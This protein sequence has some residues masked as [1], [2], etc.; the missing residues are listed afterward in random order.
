MKI[1]IYY[2][3][4]VAGLFFSLYGCEFS[5]SDIPLTEIEKPSE[6]LPAIRIELKP[7]MDILRIS[8]PTWVTYSVET[9]SHE[10][11]QI[12]LKFDETDLV[13]IN[14]ESPQKLNAYIPADQIEDGMHQLKITTYIATNSGSIAD[15][16]GYEHY[17]YTITWPVYINKH[18]KENLKFTDI[19]LV[20]EGVRLRWPEYSYA[21][22]LRY[23]LSWSWCNNQS[24][25]INITDPSQNSY[26]DDNYVEGIYCS[27]FLMIDFKGGDFCFDQKDFF[28]NIK[29]PVVMVNGDRSVDIKWSHSQNEKNVSLYCIK[30]SAPVYGL[31]EEHDITDLNE[32]TLRL[33]RSIGFGGNYNVQ[34]RYIPKGYDGY[35]S[36]YE[37][38][39]GL[40]IFAL[41]DSIPVF[42][43]AFLIVEENS[44]LI[45]NNGS[46]TK[47]DFVTG[48][49]SSA[50]SLPKDPDFNRLKIACSPDGNYFGYFEDKKYVV[51]RSSDLEII[52][53]LNV[54][55]YDE[56]NLMIDHVSISENGLIAT[57]CDNNLRI[58]D[59]ANGEKIFERHFNSFLRMAIISPDGKNLAAMVSNSVIY[60]SFDG[61]QLTEIGRVNEVGHD[62]GSVMAYSPQSEQKFVVSYWKE[63]YQYNVEVRD[64]RSFELIYSVDVPDMF[65]PIIYDFTADRVISQYRSFPVERYSYLTDMQSGLRKKIVHFTGR[66]PMVFSGGIV[67]SGN[68]RSINIDNNILE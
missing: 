33:D 19:T 45:N 2:A 46:A 56:F 15:K 52:N 31:P 6:T 66:E 48:E 34:L 4:L 65:V 23:S 35:H 16:I 9:G 26:L 62:V 43:Q 13:N 30:T 63:M 36:A 11:Y 10:L 8:G 1:S 17:W 53:K 38:A 50:L 55:A 22:F 51:R 54:E 40:T 44:L 7:D 25:K 60:Y 27:Y 20:P 29:N 68:G 67:Y 61:D 32:T 57:A 59:L 41:G 14:Y 28:I 58:F 3:I 24:G 12:E 5:P 39:G 21:D 18:A 64:S 47:W 42:Q 49:S 37:T